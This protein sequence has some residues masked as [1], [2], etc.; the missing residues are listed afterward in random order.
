MSVGE[1]DGA[2]MLFQSGHRRV[3]GS[4]RVVGSGSPRVIKARQGGADFTGGSPRC[5]VSLGRRKQRRFR[6]G[7][8]TCALRVQGMFVVGARGA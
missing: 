3:A 2:Q 7:A 5:N 8:P 6:G 4:A 1:S